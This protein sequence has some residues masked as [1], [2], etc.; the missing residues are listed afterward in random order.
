MDQTALTPMHN[1]QSMQRNL[2]ACAFGCRFRTV[3]FIFKYAAVNFKMEKEGHHSCRHPVVSAGL[4]P[5]RRQNGP[6]AQ[7]V[8]QI[9]M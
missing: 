2:C 1:G 8:E 4:N 3:I 7:L 9:M 5:V 6:V